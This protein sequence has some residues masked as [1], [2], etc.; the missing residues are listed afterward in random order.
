M[1]HVFGS[2]VGQEE[3]DELKTT[4]DEQWLGMGPKVARFEKTFAERCGFK[5]FV[6]TDS[7][8]NSLYLAVKLLNLQ[9]GTE[10]ILPSF[11]FI[12]CAQAVIENNCV[13]VFCDV[14]LD[15]QNV[16]A[17]HIFPLITK[18]TGAIMV[19]HYAGLPVNMKPIIELG[20][21]VIEDAAHA[22]DSYQ[23]GIHCGALGDIGVF[24]FDSAKNL[25][26]GEGGGIT[27]SSPT[28][29]EK[30]RRLRYCGITE[31]GFDASK[32]KKQWWETEVLYN[33]LRHMPND[34]TASIAL[35]QLKKLD[36]FQA[37]RKHVWEVYKGR[38]KNIDGL[39]L[40]QD[41][42]PNEQHSYFTFFIRV[43]AFRTELA[44]YLL[45]NGIYTTLRFYPIHMM[46]LF[47]QPNIRLR[48]TAW[49]NDQG[50]NLPLH[51]RL[52]DNNLDFIISKILD[53]WGGA[54]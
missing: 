31:S 50:L 28:F 8:S 22:V 1:I 7:A 14:D 20:I 34:V 6:M 27:A 2:N 9:P 25:S 43:H 11:T 33:S 52:T 15:T 10:I 17:E 16:T 26:T 12:A 41:P 21:P 32:T 45:Q 18:K 44:H 24:S 53:F 42:K 3:L 5:N 47:K 35:A 23:N 29:I 40:P 13:P 37:A 48:N 51:Q 46:K 49:L 30:V 54:R 38:L 36:G 4:F 19:V 39:T